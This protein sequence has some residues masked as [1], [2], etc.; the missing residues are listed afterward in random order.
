MFFNLSFFTV[1]CILL[2]EY[3]ETIEL[4]V[5]EPNSYLLCSI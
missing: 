5:T 3:Q 2:T 1:V 4:F